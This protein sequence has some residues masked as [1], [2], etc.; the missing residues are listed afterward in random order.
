MPRQE[1]AR[2]GGFRGGVRWAEGKRVGGAALRGGGES[3][4]PPTR[5]RLNVDCLLDNAFPGLRVIMT[6]NKI[7]NRG[8]CQPGIRAVRRQGGRQND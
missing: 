3:G 5:A 2:V 7:K 4:L 8:S 6:R 1:N